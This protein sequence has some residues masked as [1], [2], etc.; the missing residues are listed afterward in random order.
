MRMFEATG[1]GTCLLTDA[2]T[3]INELFEVGK[4]V[5]VY[6]SVD[7]AGEKVRYLLDNEKERKDIARAGHQ[8]TLKEH[9]FSNRCQL[10]D[11]VIRTRL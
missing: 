1:V 8:R 4:E 5:V 7:E 11:E 10:I 6:S 9:T 3:N 2:G